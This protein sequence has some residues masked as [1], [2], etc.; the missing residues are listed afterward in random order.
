ML[1]KIFYEGN[2]N[3]RWHNTIKTKKNILNSTF[4]T[5]E[6]DGLKHDEI[7]SQRKSKEVSEM[8]EPVLKNYKME[9]QG[10]RD[11]K[12]T[13]IPIYIRV[14]KMFGALI[15]LNFDILTDLIDNFII[16]GIQETYQF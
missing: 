3:E 14:E 13:S 12:L 4:D 16:V 10:K 1:Y 8:L 6:I 7:L 15:T 9:L 11:N 2:E 5:L